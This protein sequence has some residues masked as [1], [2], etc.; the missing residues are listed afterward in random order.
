MRV[1][2]AW[3]I[4]VCM[5]RYSAGILLWSDLELRATGVKTRKRL[6]VIGA[7]Q[8]K[9][10]VVRKDGGRGLISVKEK[11]LGL[12]EYVKASD[13]SKVVREM[14]QVGEKKAKYKKRWRRQGRGCMG[15]L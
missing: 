2:N 15:S 5:V 12:L 1:I 8:K 11:K 10:S 6:T 7:F 3:A 4:H 9:G 14:L 13:K